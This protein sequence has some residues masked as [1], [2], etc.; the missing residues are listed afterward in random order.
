MY[1][2][3]DRVRA[4]A[5]EADELAAE[6]RREALRILEAR[7]VA[8]VSTGADRFR[9]RLEEEAAR[10]DRPARELEQAAD[11]LYRHAREC[12]RRL[13]EIAAAQRWFTD[14][15]AGA[16]RSARAAAEGLGEVVT[17]AIARLARTAPATGSLDWLDFARR[18]GR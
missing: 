9:H 17:P 7:D 4:L 2:D 14:A 15:A 12:E 11:E 10:L 18:A 16:W 1:G 13:E 5:R 8:W 3:P 6:V